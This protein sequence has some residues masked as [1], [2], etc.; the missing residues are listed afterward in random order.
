MRLFYF[1]ESMSEMIGYANVGYLY[2]PHK[3]RSHKD[4]LVTY[5]GITISWHSM[6]QTL[7]AISNHA[8][9]IVVHKASRNCV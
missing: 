6:K 4:Y 3:A 7:V 5:G 1:N 9:I 8:E 2:D